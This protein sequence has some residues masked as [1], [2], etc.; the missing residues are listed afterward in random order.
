MTYDV[1]DDFK[2]FIEQNPYTVALGHPN[3]GNTISWRVIHL[4][5]GRPVIAIW[6]KEKELYKDALYFVGHVAWRMT[7]G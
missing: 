7:Y 4:L 5:T 1:S 3:S 2:F 6:N